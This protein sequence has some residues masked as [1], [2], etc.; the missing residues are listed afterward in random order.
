MKHS[1]SLTKTFATMALTLSCFNTYAGPGALVD[2]PLFVSAVADPN[3]MILADTSGSMRHI[4]PEDGAGAANKYDASKIEYPSCGA[5]FV[6]NSTSNAF[7]HSMYLNIL[8]GDVRVSVFDRDSNNPKTTSFIFEPG[9]SSGHICFSTNLIYRASLYADSN[10]TKTGDRVPGDGSYSLYTGNYLNWYFKTSNTSPSWGSEDLKPGVNYRMK[11]LKTTLKSIVNSLSDNTVRLGLAS[12]DGTSGAVINYPIADLG[13][14]N[15]GAVTG[16]IDSFT[17]GSETPMAEALYQIGRYFVGDAGSSNPG[18]TGSP[19]YNG[20][21]DGNLTL[22]PDAAVP[23]SYNR[24]IL[25]PNTL[26]GGAGTRKKYS[27]FYDDPTTPVDNPSTPVDE[28]AT[29]DNIAVDLESPIQYWCQNNFVVFMSD[30]IS[31]EDTSIPDASYSPLKLFQDYDGDCLALGATDCDPATDQKITNSN[32][33]YGTPL[34]AN[35]PNSEKGSDFLDDVA[36]AL[37][38]IDLRPDIDDNKGAKITN[39]IVTYTIAFADIQALNNKLLEDAAKQG[40]GQYFTATN[41]DE[42]TQRFSAATT[43]ILSTTSS[44]AAVTFNTSSLDNDTAVYQALFSTAL[45]SGDI[46]SFPVSPYTGDIDI[47][48]TLDTPNCWSAAT[49]LDAL[50]YSKRQILT[51]DPASKKGIPF[52]VLTGTYSATLPAGGITTDMVKDICA[53][54]DAPDLQGSGDV[55]SY[56]PDDA[57]DSKTYINQMINYIRGDRTYEDLAATPSFRIRNSR[58]GDIINSTP[59]F[60]GLPKLPWSSV[61]DTSNFFGET[62]KRYSDFKTDQANRQG[63]LYISA[64]DGMLHAFRTV[65]KTTT[66]GI[67]LAAGDELFAF[68]PSFVFSNNSQGGYHYLATPAYQHKYYLDLS[69]TF[70]DVYTQG[71][72]TDGSVDTDLN[73]RTVLIGGS[74]GGEK[75]GFFALDVTKPEDINESNASDKVLWEFTNVA[76]KGD[77]DLGKTYSKPTI[78]LTNALKGGTQHRWAAIFGNGYKDDSS[79]VTTPGD[80]RAKLFIVFIDGGLDGTWTEGTNPNT[81]DYIKIDTGSTYG[82][83]TAKDCNGLSTPAL[84]DLDGDGTVDRVYA[85]DVKGNMWVFDLTAGKFNIPYTSSVPGSPPTTIN[86]PLFKAVD[87]DGN[88]QPIM[89]KP[90]LARNTVATSSGDQ[91]VMVMFGTGQYIAS[92]DNSILDNDAFNTFYSIWDEGTPKSGST[93]GYGY[94]TDNRTYYADQKEADSKTDPVEAQD[95]LDDGTYKLVQQVVKLETNTFGAFRSVTS[96]KID[97]TTR[98]GWYI[99]LNDESKPDAKERVVVNPVIRSNVIFFN[100]LIPNSEVCGFGGSGWLMSVDY[101]TGSA[102]STNIFDVSGNGIVDDADSIGDQNDQVA[103]GQAINSIPAGSGII[104]DNQYT[105]TSDESIN[106]RKINVAAGLRKGRLSWRELRDD[107]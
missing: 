90:A 18:F 37:F 24:T 69:L 95:V 89:V 104:G 2:S 42:L 48:C 102:T 66:P 39:N 60:V 80:C 46:N 13:V 28:S 77:V 62:S 50:D 34:D 105:Q 88:A 53:G 91:N 9:T 16:V 25:F 103:V 22:H 31:N 49:R 79:D 12:F 51:F 26:I 78:A 56:D 75:V 99:D 97:W 70:S 72:K 100:T 86:E 57:D 73:W 21:F 11:A 4:L 107:N 58:L 38:E 68:M 54:P 1:F 36:Q 84:A 8:S 64:N 17:Q 23:D 19:P 92:G 29:P 27:Y 94:F 82:S 61:E 10:S 98:K 85:G 45:W 83:K 81:A 30:G 59:A 74:R 15:K 65:D 14:S 106:K 87:A 7:P 96:Y 32:Y 43:N 67:G 6:P 20:H 93:K 71:K 40:G 3:I 5:A 35:D 63:V 41:A 47:S 33:I 55:C 101:L 52:N 44:A 76:G